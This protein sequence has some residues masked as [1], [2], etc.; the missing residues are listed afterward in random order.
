L[1]NWKSGVAR[2]IIES[3]SEP[4]VVARERVGK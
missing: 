4:N 2:F 1:R 3:R